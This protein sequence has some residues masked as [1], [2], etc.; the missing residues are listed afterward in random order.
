MFALIITC[1]LAAA[2]P[3]AQP[4]ASPTAAGGAARPAAPA[5]PTPAVSPAP[6]VPPTQAVI[7]IHGLCPAP[8]ATSKSAK[9]AAPAAACTTLIT[10]AQL[11]KLISVLNT[12]NQPITPQIRRQF[13]QN[14][15][16][17]LVYGQAAKKAGT[18]DADFAELLRFV[19]LS[20]LV[21]VYRSRLEEQYR[22]VSDA[23]IA[24]YYEQNSAKYEE[25]NL[26]RIFI[27]A[28][29]PSAQNKDDW[30]KKAAQVAQ[31]IH[32]RAAKGEDLEKLE[33]EAYTELGLTISPASTNLG[34]RRRAM[35]TPQQQDLF[36]LRAGDVSKV[37]QEP[38]GYVIYK[39]Q[40]K[41]VAPLD[42]V[43]DEISRE[44][45]REKIDQKNKAITAG[46]HTDLNEQYFGPPPPPP[47]PPAGVV[48]PGAR[49]APSPAPSPQ[50]GS[51]ARP[52]PEASPVPPKP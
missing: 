11:D 23:E 5:T 25:I 47:A 37:E 3:Q 8:S 24:S 44:L 4:Q 49:P 26:G 33:K 32:D 35:L 34:P 42:K 19:R 13:A 16:E 30:E 7:T 40:S 14:Y 39:I 10:R 48:P 51:G 46:V 21:R 31:D 27:P 41:A 52:Q 45:F 20:T 6:E 18:E 38:A 43:K 2:M 1:L 36:S 12:Q 28:K 17:L 15:A 9:G 22:K 50:P 29:N